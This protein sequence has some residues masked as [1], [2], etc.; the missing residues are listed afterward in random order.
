MDKKE[1]SEIPT[2]Q[3][4]KAF[5]EGDDKRVSLVRFLLAS[6]SLAAI[7][8]LLGIVPETSAFTESKRYL[9]LLSLGAAH[10]AANAFG[11][12]YTRGVFADL[13]SLGWEEMDE[14]LARLVKE[15]DRKNP[16]SLQ[17]K[18]VTHGRNKF[19][20]HWDMEEVQKSL[21]QLSSAILPAWSGGDDESSL[22]TAIPITEV[23]TQKGLE[24]KAGSREQ[25]RGLMSQAG[26]LQ[27]D[28]FHVAHAAYITAIRK[29]L[30][31]EE[32]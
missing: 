7:G 16:D 31:E 4:G 30:A 5:P 19:S 12:A 2:F 25:L 21:A 26:K 9:M 32:R 1:V 18:L 10:E 11:G 29:T 24:I 17:C 23:I 14:R 22:T 3:V 13:Q 27:G 8:R 20:F 6:Q 15:C 28:L